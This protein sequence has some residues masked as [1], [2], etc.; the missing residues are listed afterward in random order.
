MLIYRGWQTYLGYDTG[1][2]KAIPHINIIKLTGQTLQNNQ[3]T[4][5]FGIQNID[6]QVALMRESTPT[7]IYAYSFDLVGINSEDNNTSPGP[8]GGGI[9]KGDASWINGLQ[10]KPVI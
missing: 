6:G 5:C 3:A 7:Q 8:Q 10:N 4:G 1:M 2:I 9:A